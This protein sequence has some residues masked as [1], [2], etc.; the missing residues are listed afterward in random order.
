MIT[1]NSI[2][3]WYFEKFAFVVDTLQEDR[4]INSLQDYEKILSIALWLRM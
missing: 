2:Y 1:L 4:L 3:T